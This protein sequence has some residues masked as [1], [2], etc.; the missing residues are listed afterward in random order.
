MYKRQP[1]YPYHEDKK[2]LLNKLGPGPGIVLTDT[3]RTALIADY[4]CEFKKNEMPIVQWDEADSS[5]RYTTV[6]I[7]LNTAR[8]PQFL[9]LTGTDFF[10]QQVAQVHRSG[11]VYLY[12]LN[13]QDVHLIQRALTLP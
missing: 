2:A 7:L 12:Q 3:K 13:H 8:N 5:K 4:L 9:P 11:D 10:R 6:Y 1:P